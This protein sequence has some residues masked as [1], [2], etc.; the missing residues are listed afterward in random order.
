MVATAM[1][2]DISTA[3]PGGTAG[4]AG[5]EQAALLETALQGGTA[6][7]AD[8][9]IRVAYDASTDE[10]VIIDTLG[11]ELEIQFLYRTYFSGIWSIF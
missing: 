6:V 4:D 3:F 5:W 1:S 10:F 9:K 8:T 7:G 2:S 11:R